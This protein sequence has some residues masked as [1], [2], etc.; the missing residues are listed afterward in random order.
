MKVVHGAIAHALELR[1]SFDVGLRPRAAKGYEPVPLHAIANDD[2]LDL[3]QDNAISQR[4]QSGIT[5]S[6]RRAGTENAP[7]KKI[8]LTVVLVVMCA[9]CTTTTTGIDLTLAET[10]VRQSCPAFKSG[11]FAEDSARTYGKEQIT[12]FRN[13]SRFNCRCISREINSAPACQQVRRFVLGNI[14]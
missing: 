1:K 7:M 13:E 3:D 6:V 8:F 12:T 14:E 9:A 5:A 11:S 10:P 2:V 4:N